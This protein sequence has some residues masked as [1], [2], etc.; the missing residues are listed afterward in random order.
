M[1]GREGH[2]K[3]ALLLRWL[4]LKDKGL[5]KNWKAVRDEE[6][7]PTMC[8]QKKKVRN[9]ILEKQGVRAQKG[10]NI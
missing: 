10:A 3:R 8:N 6:G 1:V 5:I 7:G 9:I 2:V 4:V